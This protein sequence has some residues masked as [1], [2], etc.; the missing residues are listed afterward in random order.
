MNKSVEQINEEMELV[1]NEMATTFSGDKLSI[2]VNPDDRR[3]L[4]NI[5]YFKVFHGSSFRKAM[6][7]TRIRFRDAQYETH[8]NEAGKKDFKLNLKDKK[9]LKRILQLPSELYDGYTIWQD[10]IMQFNHEAYHIPLKDCKSLTQEVIDSLSETDIR[11]KCIPV[12]LPITD[13]TN[14]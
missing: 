1:L 5:E 8:E 13:Y 10:T 3:N 12:D 11:K 6:D 4:Q 9:E 14:L 2:I 7:L